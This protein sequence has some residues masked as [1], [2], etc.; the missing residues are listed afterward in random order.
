MDWFALVHLLMK[1]RLISGK[2]MDPPIYKIASF[3]LNHFPLLKKIGSLKK[4]VFASIGVSSEA[5]IQS[6]VD[7][8]IQSGCPECYL[9]HCVSEYPAKLEDFNLTTIPFLEKK[10]SCKIGVSDHSYGFI[11][12]VVAT[13]LGARVIEKHLCLDRD[14]SS[15]DG[16]FFTLPE[17]FKEMANAVRDA[18]KSMGSISS[19]IDS[20][21]A[22]RETAISSDQYW[23]LKM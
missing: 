9:L 14:P 13:S 4:P 5:E 10:F 2:E 11:V 21:H 12:P 8:L 1:Q 6:A 15:I 3:E 17:E 18:H 23:F 22:K 20:E 16:Q 7:F 19:S